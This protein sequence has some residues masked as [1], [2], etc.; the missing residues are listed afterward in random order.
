MLYSMN[1][2]SKIASPK[3]RV[4]ELPPKKRFHKV[5]ANSEA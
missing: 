4:E 2:P 1:Y 3:G 5:S